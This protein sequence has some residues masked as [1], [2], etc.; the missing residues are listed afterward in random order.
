MN[1]SVV[2]M[3]FELM[4]RFTTTLQLLLPVPGDLSDVRASPWVA[5]QFEHSRTSRAN[6]SV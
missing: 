5:T 6:L 4:V 3:V 2:E 1:E